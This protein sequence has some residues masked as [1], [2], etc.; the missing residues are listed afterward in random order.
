[1]VSLGGRQ[2][3]AGTSRE[4]LPVRLKGALEKHPW[5]ANQWQAR[6]QDLPAADRDLMLFM[7]AARWAEDIRF[8]DKQHHRGPW[9]GKKKN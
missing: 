4:M 5:Y 9:R 3:A 7:Q 6:L 2:L 8:R 1:M